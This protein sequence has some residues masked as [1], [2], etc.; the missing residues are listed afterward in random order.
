MDVASENVDALLHL[1][2]KDWRR[3]LELNRR[4]QEHEGAW[5]GRE[6]RPDPVIAD[7]LDFWYTR[8]LVV[9]FDWPHWE[10][11][12]GWYRS[13]DD[14]KY[15]ALDAATALKLLTVVI[16]SAR[17]SEGELERAFESGEVPKII[18]RVLEIRGEGDLRDGPGQ[19]PPLDL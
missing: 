12:R 4:I 14:R 18:H 19:P 5:G 15:P 13:T 11:G 16:R 17:F 10:E 2:D 9:R 8:N 7:F 3:L 6:S 1:G